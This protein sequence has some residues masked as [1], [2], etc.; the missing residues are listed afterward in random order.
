MTLSFAKVSDLKQSPRQ[1]LKFI[2][3]SNF[4]VEGV[5]ESMTNVISAL[6]SLSDMH[7]LV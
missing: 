5:A 2:D 4:V 7:A 6:Q 3:F 1:Y